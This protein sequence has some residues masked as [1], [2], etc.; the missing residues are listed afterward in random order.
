MINKAKQLK[1]VIFVGIILAGLVMLINFAPVVKINTGNVIFMLVFT[2]VSLGLMFKPVSIDTNFTYSL[3]DVC[4]YGAIFIK[5]PAEAIWIMFVSSLI[6][7]SYRLARAWEVKKGSIRSE[8]V[9][10][11]FS[12]PF[13]RV[14]ITG[15]AGV[16]FVS[17][18]GVLK[19]F[20]LQLSPLWIKILSYSTCVLIFYLLSSSF[21]TLLMSMRHGLNF[22]S[23][24]KSWR[25]A[26]VMISPHLLMLAPLG[27]LLAVIYQRIPYA[28]ILL[29]V[30]IYIMH[31][32]ISTIKEVL[33]EAL[34]TIEFMSV[35]LDQ[36]D[37]YTAGHS[38]RVSLFAAAIAEKMRLTHDAVE[39][40]RKAGL[41]HDLG[42]IAIP[43]KVL[44][45]ADALNDK[46][47]SVM[48]A[49]THTIALLFKSLNVIPRMIPLQ[50]AMYHHE[51][52]DGAGYIY[53]LKGDKIPLGSRILAVA[54]TYDAMTSDRPYRN[55]L[56]EEEAASRLQQAAGTQLD[57]GV[58]DAFMKLHREGALVKI[59]QEYEEESGKRLNTKTTECRTV[60]AGPQEA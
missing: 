33:Q 1:N 2:L 28:A 15:G 10:A 29:A 54:D 8:A 7:E 18:P 32:A 51:R 40:I 41:I 49:H 6:F 25:G 5:G 38:E 50:T 59:R 37:K 17:I 14:L 55:A 12:N 44:R 58:V 34:N 56:P 47:F 4:A 42:K 11:N 60:D 9:L 3:E 13:L 46:E 48:K 23:L 16:V 21:G 20:G 35:T 36:R 52:Y 45:K 43:D 53:G 22:K 27:L 31:V 30:P 24:K 39:E 57:P 19:G 26:W